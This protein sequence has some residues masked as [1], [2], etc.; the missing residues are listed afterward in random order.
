M[1]PA[2]RSRLSRTPTPQNS[3]TQNEGPEFC[4]IYMQNL[5]DRSGGSMARLVELEGNYN[6]LAVDLQYLAV[7]LQYTA[8]LLIIDSTDCCWP[9]G[10]SPFHSACF[11]RRAPV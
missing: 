7:D 3:P 8:K 6:L 1:T 5:T 11:S 4:R 10:P 9:A 2:W